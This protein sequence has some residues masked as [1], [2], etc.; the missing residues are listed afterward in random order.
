M[1]PSTS[2]CIG[3]AATPFCPHC[4]TKEE[5]IHHYLMWC[6]AYTLQRQ[7]LEKQLQRDARSL[8][9]LLTNE[10]AIPH[11]IS[12]VWTSARLADTFKT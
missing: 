3:K 7:T 8:R 2:I 4:L 5:T 10:K 12:F 6:L 1:S 9:T 11:L